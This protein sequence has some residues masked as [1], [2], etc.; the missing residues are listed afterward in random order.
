M[1][2]QPLTGFIHSNMPF[3]GDLPDEVDSYFD[4]RTFAKNELF[5]KEGRVSNE[6]LVLTHGFMRAYTHD[7]EG[8][9]VTTYFFPANRAVFEPSSFFFR[10]PSSENLQA[11]TESKGYVITFDKLN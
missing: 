9:E 10:I 5:L 3:S 1:G 6:Y 8:K 2:F 11:L 7:T 4:E